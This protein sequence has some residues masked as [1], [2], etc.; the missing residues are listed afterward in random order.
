MRYNISELFRS[1]QGEG[2]FTGTPA[3][4]VRLYGC[5]VGC[6][7]CDTKYSWRGV[8]VA[9]SFASVVTADPGATI[10]AQATEG[11]IVEWAQGSGHVVLTGGE[12]LEQDIGPLVASLGGVSV[13]IETSGTVAVGE[14]VRAPNVW[15]TV[16][17]KIGQPGGRVV[18]PSVI[19]EADEV[20]MPVG[21]KRDITDLERIIAMG[22]CG[23]AEIWLQPL[24]G[25]PKALEL[26]IDAAAANGWRVSLQT[27]SLAGLR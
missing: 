27:H 20:K 12:P 2:H 24:A 16:S 10:C 5:S 6:S 3:A 9:C 13:Q 1:V 4:F 14:W 11:Q 7:Y 15:L 22:G 26:V 25:S 18:L 23:S 21:R 19:A 17:P 8:P